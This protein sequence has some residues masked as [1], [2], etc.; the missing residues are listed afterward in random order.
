MIR[1]TGHSGGGSSTAVRTPEAER[2]KGMGDGSP[3]RFR[4]AQLGQLLGKI[5]SSL[6]GIPLKSWDF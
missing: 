5:H 2:A 1:N 4:T 6:T 3:R